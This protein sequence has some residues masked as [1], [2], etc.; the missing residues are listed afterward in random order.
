[1]PQVVMYANATCSYC[2]RARRLLGDKGVVFE[3]IRVDRDRTQHEVMIRRS[4]RRTV[5]QIFIDDLH[6][7]G[8]DDLARLDARGELDPLLGL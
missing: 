5:P 3:E 7:G 2:E 6:I 8:Y 1:M 4:R